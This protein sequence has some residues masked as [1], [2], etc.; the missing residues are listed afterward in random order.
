MFIAEPST[1]ENGTSIS[2]IRA[3]VRWLFLFPTMSLKRCD[4]D[5]RKQFVIILD[6]EISGWQCLQDRPGKC[7]A[8]PQ[9][10]F[11]GFPTKIGQ[12]QTR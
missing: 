7:K 8:M 9:A 2:V 11:E 4:A 12:S 1:S 5:L 3:S 6:Q 10:I